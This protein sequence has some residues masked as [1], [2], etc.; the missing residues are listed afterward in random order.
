MDVPVCEPP[1]GAALVVD[2]GEDVG[3]RPQVAHLQEH[4]IR[5]T[6]PEEKIMNECSARV[7]E[8]RVLA[9]PLWGESMSR[10]RRLARNPASW[11]RSRALSRPSSLP[12]AARASRT[13]RPAPASSSVGGPPP[14]PR[15]HHL[16]APAGEQLVRLAAVGRGRRV[17]ARV[18]HRDL[19]V[20]L[21]RHARG[22]ARAGTGPCPRRRGTAPGSNGPER[23]QQLGARGDA[24]GDRPAH[25]AA[26]PRRATGRPRGAGA[27]AA[28]AGAPAP[29]SSAPRAARQRVGAALDACGR[30]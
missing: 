23:P 7:S 10:R 3:L 14:Q 15:G 12:R 17:A 16:A 5:S 4:A 2:R 19:R 24:G 26:A 11:A 30:G 18:H 22:C 8:G 21:G 25:A 28:R 1:L 29:G 13:W 20:Q 27:A 9:S 6:E